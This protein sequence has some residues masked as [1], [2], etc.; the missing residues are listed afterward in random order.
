M[1]MGYSLSCFILTKAQ[2]ERVLFKEMTILSNLYSQP[3]IYIR[4]PF[5]PIWEVVTEVS[6]I[7][8]YSNIQCYINYLPYLG[9]YSRT[10]HDIYIH[11]S[12]LTHFREIDPEMTILSTFCFWAMTK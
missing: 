6:H 1:A 12:K 2:R 7:L 9:S 3:P 11:T 10:V 8:F 5:S 4:H